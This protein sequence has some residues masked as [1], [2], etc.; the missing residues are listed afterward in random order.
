MKTSSCLFA[1][2]ACLGFVSSSRAQSTNTWSNSPDANLNWNGFNWT[3]DGFSWTDGDDAIF[4][5]T[6]VGAITI[7]TPVTARNLT[8][9]SP[10]YSVS[11]STLTL[12]GSNATITA[13]E[14][15]TIATSL[16]GTNGLTVEGAATLTLRGDIITPNG[17]HYTGG[18]HVKSGTLILQVSNVTGSGSAYAVDGI[19]SLDAGATVKYF[20]GYD[21]VN[22]LR[23]P[24]GQIPVNGSATPNR[25]N[26]T[27]GTLDLNGDDNQNRQPVPSGTG[28]IRNSSPYAR[29]VLKMTG[30]GDTRTFSG[31][32]MDG[33]PV[34]SSPVSGKLANR[35]E[36]DFAGGS[37]T[38]VLAGSNSFTGF[39]RI[40]VGGATIKLEG[41][42]TLGY[43][44]TTFCPGRHLIHNT[45]LLD[46]NGTSQRVGQ[47]GGSSTGV[48]ANNASNTTS[49]L[50]LCVNYTNTSL[51]TFNG[52]I[53]DNTTGTGGVL[54]LTKVGT[55]PQGL[56]GGPNTY[57]GD[58]TVSNGLL[59]IAA[60]A[61][62]SPNTTFRLFTGGT[63]NLNY[64]GTVEVKGLFING[65][66]QPDGTYGETTAPITGPGFIRVAPFRIT[67]VIK[68]P[69][70]DE[71]TLTWNSMP[72][73]S[74]RIE[75]TEDFVNWFI[76]ELGIVSQGETTTE[77]IFAFP[78]YFY[79]IRKE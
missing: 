49:I 32:I 77:T 10:G 12:I 36:L 67:S 56:T 46:L 3:S 61:A 52:K 57:S 42:G 62:V 22:N 30:Y 35:V 24:E 48:I 43:P 1:L 31:Q 64:T 14:S 8:F 68:T 16:L 7:T 9:N 41:A 72:F 51:Q 19:E 45:G 2:V 25:L 18:T 55:A 63:L 74:Y 37:G 65:V 26:M 75:G 78:G 73:A 27:G 66:A 76:E 20:N 79:R 6:G 33:G 38:L 39:I 44:T 17:N 34:T 15:V 23:I 54:G 4:G 13:N 5:P 28:T 47:Y 60:A 40:G 71:L 53:V 69:E 59:T 50:T 58:T 21:G 11:N 29:A 70:A